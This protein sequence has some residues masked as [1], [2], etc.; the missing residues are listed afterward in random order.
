MRRSEA[1]AWKRKQR[2]KDALTYLKLAGH[3]LKSGLLLDVGCGSGYIT[4]Y[5]SDLGIKAIGVDISKEKV[6]VAKK[7]IA[8]TGSFILASGLKLPFRNQYFATIILNDVLEHVPYDLA[9]PILIE[10]KRILKMEGM[11]YISVANRYQV[12]EPHTLIPF[13]TWLPRTCWNPICRLIR[14]RQYHNYYPYTI[15]LLEKLCQEADLVFTNYT[16]FYAL[17]KISNIE[18]IGDPLL[19]KLVEIINRFKLSKLAYV[20]AEK[21]SVILFICKKGNLNNLDDFHRSY[22][23]H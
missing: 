22:R 6:K 21:V 17:N 8:T 10:I 23:T 14:K 4:R 1:T 18:Q 11:L 3:N 13:L 16:W 9:Y 15:G 5:F 20:I 19:K 12:R 7:K 2:A